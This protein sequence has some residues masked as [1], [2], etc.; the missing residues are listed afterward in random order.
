MDYFVNLELTSLACSQNLKIKK[1]KPLNVKSPLGT[2]E[3]INDVI[4]LPIVFCA[5][6]QKLKARIVPSLDVPIIL[7]LDAL[8]TFGMVIDFNS[9][10]WHFS[11]NPSKSYFFENND[12]ISNLDDEPLNG[13]MKLPP[14]EKVEL[15]EFLKR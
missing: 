1:V 3:K 14:S 10:T 15:E 11:S 12:P 8:R 13:L 5:R 9:L 7:G 6:K 2:V 4:N